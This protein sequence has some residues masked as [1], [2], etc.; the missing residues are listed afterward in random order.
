MLPVNLRIGAMLRQILGHCVQFL[1]Q[2]GLAVLDAV[3][4]L[5]HAIETLFHAI[6]TLFHAANSFA[7]PPFNAVD[8]GV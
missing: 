7:E 8:L 2:T 4:T 5:F 1:R 6:E 3:K